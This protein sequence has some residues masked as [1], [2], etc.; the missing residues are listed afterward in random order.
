MPWTYFDGA[1]QVNLEMCG[2]EVTVS[3]SA[4]HT[5]SFYLGLG[6]CTELTA[7]T[8]LLGLVIQKGGG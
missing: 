6:Y 8:A 5:F 4:F 1:S 2:A 3:L 7:L